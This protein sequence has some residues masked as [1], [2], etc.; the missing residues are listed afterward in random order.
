MSTPPLA[1]PPLSCNA[2]VTVATPYAFAAGVNVSVPVAGLIVGSAENK[3]LLF[4]VTMKF[5]ACPASFGPG[6][7]FFAHPATV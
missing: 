3:A 2:T 1:V 5:I 7:M 4:V 6:E